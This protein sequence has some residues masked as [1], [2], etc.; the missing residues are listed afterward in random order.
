MSKLC[1]SCGWLAVEFIIFM[2]FLLGK[3]DSPISISPE[4]LMIRVSKV[5]PLTIELR[6]S[7]FV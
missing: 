7:A 6:K 4:M 2:G 5:T 1:K 3:R